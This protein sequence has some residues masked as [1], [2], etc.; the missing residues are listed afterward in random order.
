M[1]Q[2]RHMGYVFAIT[3]RINNRQKIVKQQYTPHM[4]SQYGELR[5]TSG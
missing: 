3:A 2:N 1:T 4:F 5:S